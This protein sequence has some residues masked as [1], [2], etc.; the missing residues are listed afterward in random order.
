MTHLSKALNP[1]ANPLARSAPD[2]ELRAMKIMVVDDDDAQIVILRSILRRAGYHNLTVLQDSREALET[3]RRLEPDLLLLDM[4]MPHLSGFQVMESLATLPA[5]LQAPIVVLTAD[6]RPAVKKNVLAGGAQ[7]FVA[8]PY[9]SAEVVLRVRNL[10]EARRSQRALANHNRQLEGQVAERTQQLEQAHV[11]MLVRLARAAE[12]RDDTSGEHVWRVANLTGLLARELGLDKAHTQ[13]LTRAARLHDVGKIAIP[14]GILLKR[15]ALTP[16]EFEVIKTHTTVG[17]RLL[18][19]G[20][21]KLMKLAESVALTHH[22]RWDGAGYPQGLAGE[23]IPLEGRIVAVADAYDALTHDRVHQRACTP[24]EAL[25]EIVRQRGR[26]FDP[27][28]VGA[29][30]RLYARGEVA[31]EAP[32]VTA[33]MF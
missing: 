10:L 7:D 27:L 22:E 24:A 31:L 1:L 17:A 21:S 4:N 5:E 14:D 25:Q 19:G 30:E 15:A 33:T 9:D 8:K 26:Q 23:A 18:S 3:F 12:Y 29:F 6:A 13:L 32:S 20:H 11:E 16:Q 2:E 28:V